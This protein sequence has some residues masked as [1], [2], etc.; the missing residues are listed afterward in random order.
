MNATR[1]AA[2]PRHRT[3]NPRY[4]ADSPVQ[5]CPDLRVVHRAQ[6]RMAS[7]P[8]VSALVA[9][10]SVPASSVP[11][12]FVPVSYAAPLATTTSAAVPLAT[13][14]ARPVTP[15]APAASPLRLTRRGR[16]VVAVM[17]A[18]L[19][20]GLSLII[21]GAAQATSHTAAPHATGA[22]LAR[23]VVRPG[24]SLWSVAETSDPGADTRLVI[25][26]IAQLNGLTSDTVFAG[27]RLWVPRS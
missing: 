8:V 11:A 14:A 26:Q 6:S 9:A 22:N 10:P 24:Q 4:Q 23:V 18:L 1:T 2:L 25:Q 7:A 20:A 17:A 19:V 21:A 12:Q 13:V 27:Q 3:E 15:P 16:I 5:F